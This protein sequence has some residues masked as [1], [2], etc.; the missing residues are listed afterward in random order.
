MRQCGSLLVALQSSRMQLWPKLMVK[1]MT[2]PPLVKSCPTEVQASS[3]LHG[4]AFVWLVM[5]YHLVVFK[6]IPVSGLSYSELYLL[7][8]SVL[9]K[10]DLWPELINFWFAILYLSVISNSFLFNF[11]GYC[12]IY[13]ILFRAPSDVPNLRF[14][15]CICFWC[16]QFCD[17]PPLNHF[18]TWEM[19]TYNT[20]TWDHYS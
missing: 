4:Y 5:L 9:T 19:L 17:P 8:F 7:L 6:F 16:M 1:K 10:F 20:V 2:L 3:G 12:V 15:K 11:M 13:H 14:S 18:W